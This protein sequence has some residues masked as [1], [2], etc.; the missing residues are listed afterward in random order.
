MSRPVSRLRRFGSRAGNAMVEFALGS[1]ILVSVFTGTFQY[2]YIFYQYNA[3]FNAVN[4]GAHFA[5]LQ[6]YDTNSTTPSSAYKTAVTNM[7]VYGDPT[8]TNTT[9]VV[10]GLAASN[11]SIT[12][13]SLGSG[14]T[15]TPI[16]VTVAINNYTING[17][18]G[19]YALTNKPAVT[20]PFQ[21]M[22]CPDSGVC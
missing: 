9:P 7:V 20:Y 17:V 19:T 22:Y 5:A 15:F 13:G 11:V 1:A 14:S 10:K 4:N 16:S 21:G 18:M 3:L 8:G 2:G 6:I 12:I